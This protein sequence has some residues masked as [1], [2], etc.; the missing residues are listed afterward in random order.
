MVGR[1]FLSFPQFERLQDFISGCLSIRKTL[2]TWCVLRKL[3]MTEVAVTRASRQDQ[4]VV[5]NR[6]ILPVGV[7]NND[8]LLILSTP[9][10]SPMITVVFF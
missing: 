1:I 4:R 2:Q 9:V 8:A 6:R 10:T 5:G 7:A 3:T